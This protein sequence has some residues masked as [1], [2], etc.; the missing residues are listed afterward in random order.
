M[1]NLILWWQRFLLWV[2]YSW[3]GLTLRGSRKRAI[4]WVVGVDEI[5]SM[6]TQIATVIPGS[7]SVSFQKLHYYSN[8]FG[9]DYSIATPVGTPR[10]NRSRKFFGPLLFG[11]LAHEAQGII[12]VGGT[13]FLISWDDGREYE[14]RWAK[15]HGL[16]VVCYWTGSD[17]RSL[18]RMKKLE[19]ELQRPNIATYIDIAAP[20][21]GSVD[22]EDSRRRLAVA[23]DRWAD[24]MF[25]N[26]IDHLSYLKTP[27]E[28]FLYFLPDSRLGDLSQF[29]DVT[30]PVL[31]HATTSP[32]IKGT[33]LVRAAVAKLRAEGYEFEYVELMGVTNDVVIGQLA[34]S[35][36]ALNQF[37]GFSTSVF[38]AEGLCAGTVVMMS[39]DERIET[40]F[41]AGSND[42]WVV[43]CHYEVYD[44]LKRLLDDPLQWRAIAARGLAWAREYATASGASPRLH[45]VL[46]AV[47][48]GTYSPPG[49]TRE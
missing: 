48:D 23:A 12:Y 46:D 20:G 3:Y 41:A 24:A 47:L 29:D 4:S 31:V 40:D 5:A 30:R 45:Q 39:A 43:T 10:H 6:V 13:G 1:A 25:S 35:H 38:G 36:I 26:S 33:Q 37:Y 15:R 16:K 42:A 34:K 14:M 21:L 22:A 19:S 9:Y 11:R 44:N 8:K 2:S 28:P 32:I 27:T 18:D 7:Y 17:I 49:V